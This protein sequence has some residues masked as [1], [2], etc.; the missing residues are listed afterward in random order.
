VVTLL[1]DSSSLFILTWSGYSLVTLLSYHLSCVLELH[2]LQ[3]V[4]YVLHGISA[5]EFV[6]VM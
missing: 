2:G 3:L 5:L 4:Y 6:S 1:F